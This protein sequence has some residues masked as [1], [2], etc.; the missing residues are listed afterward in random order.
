MI[1]HWKHS[2]LSP[3]ICRPNNFASY[4]FRTICFSLAWI[5]LPLQLSLP[6]LIYEFFNFLKLW[7]VLFSSIVS[8]TP[9]S[10]YFWHSP[11]MFSQALFM[12]VLPFKSSKTATFF[13]ILSWH[14]SLK[15]TSFS[16]W[17]LNLSISEFVLPL[18]SESYACLLQAPHSDQHRS[19]PFGTMD[20]E[21]TW[22][23]SPIYQDVI[24]FVER[25]SVWRCPVVLINVLVLCF[26]HF[27]CL[28]EEIHFSNAIISLIIAST[29]ILI[30]RF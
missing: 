21:C 6:S 30:V 23:L 26:S 25:F 27:G 3:E 7:L 28:L 22:I 19:G 11:L 9:C 10:W 16:F 2:S 1:S 4:I 8:S 18:L 5:L 20:I 15:T 29:L 13:Q 12:S 17:G 14:C 24:I